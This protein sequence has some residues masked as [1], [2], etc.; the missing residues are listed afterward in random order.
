MSISSQEKLEVRAARPRFLAMAATYFLGVFNDNFFKQAALLLAVVA[1]LSGLQGKATMLFSL[2]FILFSA[3]GGWL[4]D[5][6]PKRQ[7]IIGAKF[8]EGTAMLMGAY[9]IVTLS[10]GWILSM[11]FL[12]GLQSSL[13]GPALNGSIPELYPSWYVTKANALLKLV[14]T[15]AILIGMAAAGIALDQHWLDT[16]IPFGR[17]L[18]AA[19]VLV[20]AL[21]GIITSFGIKR[22]ESTN[23]K[24]PFPW[25][26]PIVSLQDSIKLRHDPPL[27]LA[28]V[29][30][31][32]FYFLSLIAVMLINTMGVS[33]LNMSVT[34][35]SLLAV[36]MMV[37]V[38]IGSLMAAK[39]TSSEH[40]SH[41][42][43]PA[44][45]G[46][47]AC[48]FCTGVV[49]GMELDLQW[50]LLLLSLMGVGLFGGIFLIPLT[51]FIQV[52]PTLDRKGKVIAAANFCAFSGMLIAG[53]IFT[54]LDKNFLPS[55]NML[56]L[57]VFGMVSAILFSVG[58]RFSN[59][60]E[61]N[62]ASIDEMN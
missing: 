8:L 9:G 54:I 47:G 60:S 46:M 53:P 30:D 19:T 38:C 3:Y 42:L 52:R 22:I 4:A 31:A 32:Y 25:T 48:L 50:V 43:G 15:V 16:D 12:M 59:P 21:S 44:C 36:S 41:V 6:F 61:F 1:G 14:T 28:V 10:W 37:G 26:G 13:F 35:T 34:A 24:S 33:Q 55:S 11:I 58:S 56:F 39:I 57:G 2:P 23:S 27:L 45:F 18:V 7:V 17:L 40:W 20:V 51:A 49:A 29:G 62:R 5:R